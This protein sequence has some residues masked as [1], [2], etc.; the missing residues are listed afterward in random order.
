VLAMKSAGVDGFEGFVLTNTQLA[1]VS[2]LK[3]QGVHLKAAML[4]T[5]YGGDLINGGPGA[6][7]VAQGAY[8]IFAF[9]PVEMHTPAT[10][11]L[12]NALKTYAEVTTEPTYAE[13]L[14]YSSVDAVAT[15]LKDAG[16]NPTQASFINAMLG[17][18][19]FNPGGLYGTHSVAFDMSDRGK[20]SGA[21]NCTW[22]AQYSGSSFHLFSGLDPIC[23]T[24]IPGKKVSASS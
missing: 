6:T 16:G 11:Q 15:G 17:I 14:G 22:V 8:F 3:E 19:H 4:T 18:S 2:G 20:T 21:D 23:G 24:T 5:G 1:L 9:E 13:Y 10:E 12:Q 7:Q